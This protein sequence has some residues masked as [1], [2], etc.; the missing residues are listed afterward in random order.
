MNEK[1]S[2]NFNDS[3]SSS[4]FYDS[5]SSSALLDIVVFYILT[6]MSILS[7]GQQFIVDDLLNMSLY[8]VPCKG[9]LLSLRVVPKSRERV[10]IFQ[11]DVSDELYILAC[12]TTDYDEESC[13]QCNDKQY[14]S[15][16]RYWIADTSGDMDC[17]GQEL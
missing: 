9:M 12:S 11:N 16:P 5:K 15:P 13:T 1:I 7:R 14:F 8:E 2:P 6:Y 3:K 10:L 4:N 17:R